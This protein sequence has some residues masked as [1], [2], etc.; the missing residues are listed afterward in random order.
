MVVLDLGLAA[1]PE[2]VAV[3]ARGRV[4]VGDVEQRHLGAEQRAVGGRVLADAEQRSGADRVQVGR[5]AGDLELAERARVAPG[6][7]GRW[8]TA[9]RPGGR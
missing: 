5:V 1:R 2:R 4:E 9:D 6:R 7:R 3:D 8:R